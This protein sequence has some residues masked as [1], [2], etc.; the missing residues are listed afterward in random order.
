MSS[1]AGKTPSGSA[2]ALSLSANRVAHGVHHASSSA[3][4]AAAVAVPSG[5][6]HESSQPRRNVGQ[7]FGGGGGVSYSSPFSVGGDLRIAGND[8]GSGSGVVMKSTRVKVGRGGG[9]AGSVGGGSSGAGGGS[10]GGG[11]P[12]RR[13]R[14]RLAVAQEATALTDTTSYNGFDSGGGGGGGGGAEGGSAGLAPL[15]VVGGGSGGGGDHL[16]VAKPG[17]FRVL[18]GNAA[19]SGGGG[20]GSAGIGEATRSTVGGGNGSGGGADSD[21]RP[22]VVV[23]ERAQRVAKRTSMAVSSGM[24]VG[25]GEGAAAGMG[26]GAAAGLGGAIDG[27]DRGMVSGTFAVAGPPKVVLWAQQASRVATRHPKGGSGKVEMVVESEQQQQQQQPDLGVTERRAGATVA[28]VGET[29][30]AAVEPVAL[31]RREILRQV[32]A[33]GVAV[34]LGIVPLG[35]GSS[36]PVPGMLDATTRT[37]C[38]IGEFPVEHGYAFLTP[39]SSSAFFVPVLPPLPSPPPPLPAPP[40]LCCRIIVGLSRR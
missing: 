27:H 5:S 40:L 31:D 7:G 28:R 14:G 16:P 35:I 3:A 2:S 4:A 6:G 38:L 1:A 32:G 39:L 9:G 12:A 15:R 8:G 34:P 36:R 37:P 11:E 17:A 13:T 19:S 29:M 22:N 23:V 10:R 21:K 24:G 20:G 25:M 30:K 26:G 33:S 18:R